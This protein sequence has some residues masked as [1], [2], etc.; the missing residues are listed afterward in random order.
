MIDNDD[1]LNEISSFSKEITKDAVSN[2]KRIRQFYV[3][4]YGLTEIDPLRYEIC[5]CI[6][7]SLYQ[8]AVTLTNH[9]LEKYLKIALI[10]NAT[11]EKIT[12]INLETIFKPAVDKYSG[13]ELA[14]TI[15]LC[16]SKAIINKEQKN[17]LHIYREKIRNAYSHADMNK[18]FTGMKIPVQF[19]K[20]DYKDP[21]NIFKVE[22][23]SEVNLSDFVLFQG[24][25]QVI[26]SKEISFDYFGYVDSIIRSTKEKLLK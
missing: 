3:N 13:L 14:K 23:T 20:I 16:C 11:K 15:N 6:T 21:E 17:Q 1:I 26:I 7:L 10:Y 22:H 9:L 8:A 19:G 5:I 4:E 25:A 12:K 18:T 2:Y 24:I